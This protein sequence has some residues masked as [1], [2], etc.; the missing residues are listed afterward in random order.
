MRVVLSSSDTTSL[1]DV[2]NPGPRS[3]LAAAQDLDGDGTT[4][5]LW[6][7]SSTGKLEFYFLNSD[8][9]I[10]FTTPWDSNLAGWRINSA[11]NF[12]TTG[13]GIMFSKGGAEVLVLSVRFE[14]I[15]TLPA[16]RG[17]IRV[18][19]SRVLGD[20]EEGFRVLGPAEEP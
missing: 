12:S 3:V 15:A 5:F 8:S 16:G 20:I 1:V 10:R 19:Y 9:S 6:E 13:S 14:A 2:P 4:D 18:D 17:N 11:A 7:D